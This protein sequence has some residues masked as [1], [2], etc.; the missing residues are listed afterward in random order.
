MLR[1]VTMTLFITLILSLLTD[2]DARGRVK[3]T[4]NKLRLVHP[5]AHITPTIPKPKIAKKLT[6]YN[7]NKGNSLFGGGWSNIRGHFLCT[8]KSETKYVSI[9]I[10]LFTKRLF[11]VINN[12]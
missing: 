1:I 11:Y 3:R 2:V 9:R 10:K 5:K 4:G 8:F 12:Y 7:P 6:S